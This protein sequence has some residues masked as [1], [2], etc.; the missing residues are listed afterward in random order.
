MRTPSATAKKLFE[1]I[2]AHLVG[3]G[4]AAAYPEQVR[5]TS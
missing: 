1:C 3:D 4:Q 2:P 5:V